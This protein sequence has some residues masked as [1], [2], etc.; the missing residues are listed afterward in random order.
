MCESPRAQKLLNAAIHLQDEVY[1][2]VADIEDE[3]SVF[4]ADLS[5]YKLWLESYLHEYM[6]DTAATKG[7]N[8]SSG[9]S[10]LFQSEADVIKIFF[11]GGLVYHFPTSEI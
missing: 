8:K 3:Q 5:Y 7:L 6:R 2:K 1:T 9:K 11:N 10:S 4:G